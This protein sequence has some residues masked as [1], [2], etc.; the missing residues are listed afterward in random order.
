MSGDGLVTHES[1]EWCHPDF[2][3]A[4]IHELVIYQLHP[5]TFAGTPDDSGE[6]GDRHQLHTIHTDVVYNHLG[7]SDLD[8]WRFDGFRLDSTVN[9]RTQRARR[10]LMGTSMTAGV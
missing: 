7:R 2:Q 5:A 9:I 8:L 10:A 3:L 1:F 4:P 6:L